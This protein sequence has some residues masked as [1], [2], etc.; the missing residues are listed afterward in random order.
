MVDFLKGTFSSLSRKYTMSVTGFLLGVFLLIHAAGNSFI[1][2]G[3]MA[4]NAYAEQLHSLGPLVPMVEL[5]LLFTFSIHI[6]FGLTLYLANRV[7][8]GSR[9]A[10]KH[11]AGGQT[12]GSRTMPW[13][14]LT[15]LAFLLLH[16]SNV[17]FIEE[18]ALIGDVVEQTLA[19][20]IYTL[21]YLVGIVALTLHVSHGFWSLLQTWG[22]YHPRYNRLTRLGA[23]AL[24]ALISLVFCA[25]I[26]VLW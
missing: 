2:Q 12:W 18:G 20:P 1:F 9:Y 25:V 4:F 15:L 8:T 5:L 11:S 22:L 21:L 17:R 26:V 14:G 6:I 16:L 23:W 24:A 10:V 13:T 3:K 7:A 19:N